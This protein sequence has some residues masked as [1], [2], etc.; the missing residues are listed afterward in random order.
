MKA[1]FRIAV[2]LLALAFLTNAIS[3]TVLTEIQ[4]GSASGGKIE[5]GRYYVGSHSR[6][7]EVSA[8]RYRL[9][10]WQERSMIIVP[11][12]FGVGLAYAYWKRGTLRS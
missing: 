11:P 2:G 7:T 5:G 12:M 6:Y 3:W 1:P 10:Q 4:G 8:S 9:S